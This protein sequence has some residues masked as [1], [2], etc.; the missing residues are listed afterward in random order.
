MSSAPAISLRVDKCNDYIKQRFDA[1]HRI[2]ERYPPGS[3]VMVRNPTKRNLD[4]SFTGPFEI[5][6]RKGAHYRLRGDDGIHPLD[7]SFP[8]DRLRVISR[9]A[10]EQQQRDEN[11]WEVDKIVDH[12]HSD[13]SGTKYF[14]PLERLSP[15]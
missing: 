7:G 10:E 8:P 2:V 5:I 11:M 4:P 12:T 1:T 6:E 15:V 3:F 13:A 9:A 14:T